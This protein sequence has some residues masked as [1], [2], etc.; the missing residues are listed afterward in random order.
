MKSSREYN[1]NKLA[2]KLGLV[3]KAAGYTPPPVAIGPYA[4]LMHNKRESEEDDDYDPLARRE[5]DRFKLDEARHGVNIPKYSLYHDENLGIA[6][7]IDENNNIVTLDDIKNHPLYGPAMLQ[8]IAPEL[9]GTAFRD[10]DEATRKRLGDYQEDARRSGREFYVDD[11]TGAY[12][13]GFDELENRYYNSY[14]APL[15]SG[16]ANSNHK[17]R[18]GA[19]PYIIGGDVLNKLPTQTITD[20]NGNVTRKIIVTPQT[21]MQALARQRAMG[22]SILE[23][24]LDRFFN[25]HYS[26]H[27]LFKYHDSGTLRYVIQNYYNPETGEFEKQDL[28]NID[29][30]TIDNKLYHRSYF[31]PAYQQAAAIA[32]NSDKDTLDPFYEYGNLGHVL[33]GEDGISRL[34]GAK[35]YVD[36][37]SYQDEHLQQLQEALRDRWAFQAAM[38][39]IEYRNALDEWQRKNEVSSYGSINPQTGQYEGNPLPQNIAMTMPQMPASIEGNERAKIIY[40]FIQKNAEA[41]RQ[42]G[43]ALSDLLSGRIKSTITYDE[44]GNIL[45]MNLMRFSSMMNEGNDNPV[46]IDHL[47]RE[48]SRTP[49]F[50]P[51]FRTHAANQLLGVHDDMNSNPD[52]PYDLQRGFFSRNPAYAKYNATNPLVAMQIG[53]ISDSGLQMKQRAQNDSDILAGLLGQEA[54][55]FQKSLEDTTHGASYTHTAKL[56]NLGLELNDQTY[57]RNNYTDLIKG[58]RSYALDNVLTDR[59]FANFVNNNFISRGID[60]VAGNVGKGLGYVAGG[61]GSIFGQ[62]W[63]DTTTAWGEGF[64]NM[65]G[66]VFDPFQWVYGTMGTATGAPM[67]RLGLADQN[68]FL[69]DNVSRQLEEGFKEG[70][71]NYDIEDYY[72]TSSLGNTSNLQAGN[73]ASVFTNPL[74]S[75]VVS[76]LEIS[77]PFL[78][79]VGKGLG[80]IATRG[81]NTTSRVSPMIQGSMR[82]ARKADDL[83]EQYRIIDD[84]ILR[85]AGGNNTITLRDAAQRMG[86][87]T[88]ELFDEL[89]DPS[90]YRTLFN[91]SDGV[92]DLV[93]KAKQGIIRDMYNG[94]AFNG[95]GGWAVAGADIAT[96]GGALPNTITGVFTNPIRTFVRR[97]MLDKQNR[98]ARNLNRQFNGGTQPQNWRQRLRQFASSEDGRRLSPF[99]DIDDQYRAFG[100]RHYD[101]L[102]WNP[103]TGGHSLVGDLL[104]NPM[105]PQRYRYPITLAHNSIIAPNIQ[106]QTYNPI[107]MATEQYVSLNDHTPEVLGGQQLSQH[108]ADPNTIAALNPGSGSNT[109]GSGKFPWLGLGIGAGAA[110]LG[111]YLYNKKKEEEEKRKR[112]QQMQYLQQDQVYRPHVGR[113][114]MI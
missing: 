76:G 28:S 7:L 66:D 67:D 30:T 71:Y 41:Q 14:G 19:T 103:R 79:F 63:Y 65:V 12:E 2:S 86:K 13:D 36:L 70:G 93:P 80:A 81:V 111:I 57:R 42:Q 58:Q 72:N 106:N 89:D 31:V 83:A 39:H 18:E 33:A 92:A 62:D 114:Y 60:A 9:A 27:E 44:Q 85:D 109:S 64:G 16:L 11:I 100:K 55:D 51:A 20:A 105:S 17:L 87:T 26:P 77:A 113:K 88:Q 22:E 75:R 94:S 107:T 43:R 5:V 34:G 21:V 45:P 110:G 56:Q 37:G 3:K 69:R 73:Q 4:Q 98:W 95:Q 61:V 96:L 25:T 29:E 54:A 52:D 49:K 99:D 40:D 1:I 68:E 32:M 46:F 35:D 15:H 59:S 50:V 8:H 23:D 47:G 6:Y 104:Y 102:L 74:T 10:L 38:D 82:M 24:D 84:I 90:V 53:R 112:Q 48:F 78:P 101:N 97:G 108:V 91:G